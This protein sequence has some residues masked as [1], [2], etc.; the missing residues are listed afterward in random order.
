MEALRILD[1]PEAI[2]WEYDREADVLYLSIGERRPAVGIDLG[3]GLVVRYD[4]KLGEVVGL[5]VVGLQGRL[6]E[7]LATERSQQAD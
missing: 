5:T 7:R 3:D 4:E 1:K 6:T 2:D